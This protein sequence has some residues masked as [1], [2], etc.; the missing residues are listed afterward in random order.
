MLKMDQFHIVNALPLLS[1]CKLHFGTSLLALFASIK[2][3]DKNTRSIPIENVTSHYLYCCS[4]GS[5]SC[6]QWGSGPCRRGCNKNSLGWGACGWLMACSPELG[7][8][9]HPCW[10]HRHCVMW[11]KGWTEQEVLPSGSKQQNKCNTRA[12]AIFQVIW[13][14]NNHRADITKTKNDSLSIIYLIKPRGCL[15]KIFGLATE[16]HEI[17]LIV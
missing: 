12:L 7:G 17:N 2:I 14:P 5:R 16:K 11:E 8:T 10:L 1:A 9:S 4:T 6:P 13:E 15:S 3:L